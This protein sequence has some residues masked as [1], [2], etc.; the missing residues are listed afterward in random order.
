LQEIFRVSIFLLYYLITNIRGRDHDAAH[1]LNIVSIVYGSTKANLHFTKK[2][3]EEDLCLFLHIY[4]DLKKNIA[5]FSAI[6]ILRD[7]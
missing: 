3:T 7:I 5:L 1:R 4:R 2:I 6:N